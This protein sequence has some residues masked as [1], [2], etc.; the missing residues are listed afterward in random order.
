MDIPSAPSFGQLAVPEIMKFQLNRHPMLFVD[1]I[2][3]V[4]PGKRAKGLKAFTFNE[5]FFPQHFED[6]PNVPGFVQIEA[7]AQVFLMTFLTIEGLAGMK[8]SALNIDNVRLR[9]KIIPGETLSIEAELEEFKRGI[10][11]GWARGAIGSEAAVSARFTVGIPDL[12]KIH[13]PR[14]N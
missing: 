10:A 3:E 9:R 5:W 14:D 1:R 8:A 2:T 7:L 4:V 11:K 6:D 12:I 13:L